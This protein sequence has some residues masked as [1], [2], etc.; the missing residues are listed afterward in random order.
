MI[1]ACVDGYN[2]ALPKG[3][4]IATYGHGLLA[5]LNAIGTTTQVLY[6]PT[7]PRHADNFMNE[8]ALVDAKAPARRPASIGRAAT[9]LTSR[10]GRKAYPI[11]IS[12]QV[13]WPDNGARRPLA[14]QYWASTDIFNLANRAY[15]QY[16]S[17]TPIIFEPHDQTSHP[18]VMHWTCPLP[19]R[20]KKAIN[21]FT[22]HDLIPLKLPHTTADDKRLFHDLCFEIGQ[23]ADHILTV[24]EK[25]REDVIQILKVDPSRVTT[26]YQAAALPPMDEP[27]HVA[28]AALERS[29]GLDWG[30]Y[31]LFYG[32]IEPKKN[33]GRIV[34]AFLAAKTRTP[35]VVVG[36]R[37]WLSEEE[38]SLLDATNSYATERTIL[39][40]D[41]LPV[42][43]LQR[44]IRGARATLFPS[45]YEGFG[46]PVLESMLVGTPVLTSR[47]GGLAEVA[48]DAAVSVDPYNVNAI[49]QAIRTLDSDSA[50]R[51]DLST[52]GRK[53]AERFSSAAYEAR[54]RDV[55]RNLGLA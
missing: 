8:V 19:M 50:F 55:Y 48:G 11:P 15:K 9:T 44:L 43:M 27:D 25:T 41:Y 23:K 36:G 7:V 45:L 51:Q 33:L 20:S 38:T 17:I 32:A 2:L 14:T 6:G 13:V 5:G 42:S 29:L 40:L 31:F 16:R 30:G 54:L 28:A 18:D 3:S 26:T 52:R 10:F 22:F 49:T 53:Q 12:G 46:L 39:R 37:A 35:L 34:E 4:G 21:I 1:S 47:E 24:S